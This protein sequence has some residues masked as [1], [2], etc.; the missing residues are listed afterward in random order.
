MYFGKDFEIMMRV[1]F[2]LAIIG[3]IFGGWKLVEIIIWLF[4]HIKIV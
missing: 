1:L 2:V 3:L 4:H